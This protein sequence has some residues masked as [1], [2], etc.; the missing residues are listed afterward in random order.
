MK[1]FLTILITSFFLFSC[2]HK[3]EQPKSEDNNQQQEIEITGA[4]ATFPYPLYSKMFDAYHKLTKV[5][6]NYQAIGSGGGIRQMISKTVDFGATD[7]FMNS[8]ELAKVNNSIIHIPTCLGAVVI[9]YNLPAAPN[10]KLT[11]DIIAG[12]FLGKIHNWNDK[13]IKELNPEVDFPDQKIVVV[14][15]SDGSGTSFIFSD[16]LS[17]VSAEWESSVGKGKSLNW[18]VGLGGKGNQGVAGQIQQLPGS[19]G[20][21]ELIYASSNDMSV[22]SIKNKSGNFIV[23]SIASVSLAANVALPADTRVSVTDT[24]APDGYPLSSFTWLILY[25][26]LK[27]NV[28]SKKKAEEL[29]DL[30]WWMIHKGQ[31]YAEPLHYAPIPEEAVKISENILR[32]L[33]YDGQA[34]LSK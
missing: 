9:S 2:G 33:K 6:V 12:I 32:S 3:S 24:D 8:E 16:Y 22:A 11:A 4:G 15:R 7:A 19:I 5:K 23:P 13:K 17:K 20:Y 1:H 30:I 26:D 21:V 27:T 18:P 29:V 14:H 34:I 28:K 10:L 25:K 31:K